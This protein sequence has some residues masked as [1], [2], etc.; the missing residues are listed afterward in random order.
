MMSWST[1][2]FIYIFKVLVAKRVY[3]DENDE[4]VYTDQDVIDG[5]NCTLLSNFLAS[6]EK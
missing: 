1:C 6:L 5:P 4:T 2:P 3:F